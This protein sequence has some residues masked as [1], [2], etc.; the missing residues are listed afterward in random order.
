MTRSVETHTIIWRGL[1]IEVRYERNWLGSDGPFRTA[2]L[3]VNTLAPLNAPLPFTETG[4]RSHLIETESIDAAG[5]PVA[6]GSGAEVAAAHYAVGTVPPSMTYSVP[7]IEAARSEA[8][9][10]MRLATSFGFAGRPMGMPPSP[11]IMIFLP[12]S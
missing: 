10:A 8:T 12:P 6:Y 4:Y 5:G 9:K 2:H 3:Q 11:S 1:S 7:V